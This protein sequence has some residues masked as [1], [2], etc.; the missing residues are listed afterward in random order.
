M[1]TNMFR[2]TNRKAE[3]KMNVKKSCKSLNFTLIELLVVIAIIAILAGMLLPALNKARLKAQAIKC[4]SNLK[5]LGFAL[6]SYLDDNKGTYHAAS[7]NY[8]SN[9]DIWWPGLYVQYLNK[10][11]N[12][13]SAKRYSADSVF[14]CPTLRT[15]SSVNP[16][17]YI[18]Y[19]YNA[20]LFGSSDYTP[21]PG[22]GKP[23]PQNAIKTGMI[24]NPSKQ[25]THVDT[26]R[27]PTRDEGN[28][29]LTNTSYICIRHNGYSNVLYADGHANPESYRFLL[30]ST[31]GNYPVNATCQNLP[32]VPKVPAS[33]I[34]F[35]FSPYR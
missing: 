24:K 26:W 3:T 20:Y 34:S 19:G 5:Q 23:T 32:Y 8:P 16:G 4:V 2:K 13:T 22:F 12:T 28:C 35:D 1:K 11:K 9:P 18:S 7:L 10:N 29:N 30:F 27:L 17:R 33:D 21:I 25:L 15:W 31:M 14:N 6:T